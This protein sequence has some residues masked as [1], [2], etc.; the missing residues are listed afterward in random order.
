MEVTMSTEIEKRN[1]E[2]MQ[3]L[4]DSWNS[5]DW[6]T[7]EKRHKPDTVVRW[8]AQPPTHGVRA[9]RE[10]S[11]RMFKTFP[12]NRVG[13]RPYKTLF[14][15]GDWTCSIARFTGT[16]KGPM[17]LA[18]GTTIPPTGKQFEVDFCTVAQ[19]QDGQIVQENLFY[20][21]VGMMQQ[22]GIKA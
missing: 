7:F 2:L 21:V 9:H 20:D 22:L 15:G 17:T 3:T 13:N 14:A 5:Q 11:I 10:E 18:N 8:P 16:M 19:W 12:D 6:D 4:D 1:M